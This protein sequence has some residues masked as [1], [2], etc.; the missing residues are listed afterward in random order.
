MDGY[1]CEVIREIFRALKPGGLFLNGDRYGLDD[2]LEHTRLIQEEVKQYFKVFRELDRMDLLEHW[3][4]HL[5][6]DES[7]DR[8]MRLAPA[9]EH[10]AAAGF[11]PVTVHYRHEVNALVTGI[12]P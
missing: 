8:V 5:F 9:V 3:I 1:R 2:T 10:M 4:V 7:P 11:R 12:K 6:S